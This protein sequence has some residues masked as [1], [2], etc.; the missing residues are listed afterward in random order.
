[1]REHRDV[2]YSRGMRRPEDWLHFVHF[3]WFVARWHDLG[4]GDDDLRA[5]EVLIMA[6]PKKGPVIPGTGGIRKLRFARWDNNRGRS[7]GARICYA[8]LP[9]FDVV[10]LWA[11]YTK[12]E[13]D[14]I[15]PKQRA[16][17]QQGMSRF[18]L[19]LATGGPAS[20]ST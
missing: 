13:Q 11:V 4:F 20:R 19:W 2:A 17:L 3:P 14:N 6:D 10:A 16:A 8:W 18:K 1:M 12:D 9:E 5:L 15:T 7:G